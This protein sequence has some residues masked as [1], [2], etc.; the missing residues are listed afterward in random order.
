MAKQIKWIARLRGMVGGD[1]LGTTYYR[2]LLVH[3]GFTIFTSLPGVFV[4]TFLM[5]RGGSM[6]PVLLYNALAFTGTAAGMLLSS[7]VVHRLNAGIVSVIG[8]FGYS[9]FYLQL[10]FLNSSAVD[11]VF[12]LGVTNGLASAFYWLSYSQLL[13]EYTDLQNRDSGMAIVS[14]MSSGVNVAAPLFSGF[15]ISA[16]GGVGY[17][18][19]FGLAV[20]IGLVTALGAMRLPKPEMEPGRVDHRRAL[21]LLHSQKALYYAMLGE[22][23]KGIREGAFGFILSIL[24]YRLIRSEALIGFNSFLSSAVSILSFLLISKYVIASNRIRFMKAALAFLFVFSVINVFT[25]NP[26]VLVVFTVVNSFFAGFIVN[27]SFGTFL[28]AMQL[29]P[30]AKNLRPELFALK[31]IFLATGR[32]LGVFIILL[33]DRLSGGSAM[34]QALSL[35]FLTVTQMG[36]VAASAHASSL[37]EQQ[38]KGA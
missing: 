14:I 32:C 25:M 8:I 16:L 28:D 22:S 18:T 19:V 6:D 9:L 35:V 5:S 20:A 24:L 10:I 4:N 36:T 26:F 29:I 23:C 17:N 2:F 27:S 15:L 33:L 3:T 12:L 37:V 21:R 31:E 34:W 38:K 13:T 11:H 30:E 1:S 7:S